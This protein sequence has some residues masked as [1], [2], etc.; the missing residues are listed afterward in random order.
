MASEGINKFIK[1]WLCIIISLCYCYSIGRTKKTPKGIVRLLCLLPVM[2]LFL[3]IPLNISSIHFAGTTAF[4][5]SW[6]ANF[7][8]LLFA[9]GKGPLS[10]PSLSLPRF[11]AIACFPIKIQQHT[12]HLNVYQTPTNYAIKVL[13]FA[14]LLSVYDYTHHIHPTILLV[15]YCFHVYFCLEI[16]LVTVATL[17]RALLGLEL[18]K[19]FNE[20]YLSTSL[21]D[22]WGKR[23]NLM[24]TS[25]LRPTAYEP[26]RNTAARFIGRKRALLPAVFG[27]FVVSGIMHELIF[28]YLGRVWPTWEV[29][30]FFLLHG[31]CVTAEIVLK[32][33]FADKWPLP[34]E[35]S[36]PLTVGFVMI[37]GNWLFFPPLLRCGAKERALEEYAVLGAFIKNVTTL[38]F[39]SFQSH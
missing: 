23:W 15:L 33:A 29:M 36:T 20:P 28:Y 14:L 34:R 11:I 26:V 13:L 2:C 38:T 22:F 12:S 19:Q 37:T 1:L 32:N 39:S 30:R 10:S 21:Q 9:F 27:T 17:T 18:E 35:V 3:A 24:A 4:S 8:L 5:I 31:V 25:V 7:K 16:I 6:L